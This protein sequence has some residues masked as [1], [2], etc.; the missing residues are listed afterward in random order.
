MKRI[1]T[2]I[3]LGFLSFFGISQTVS[4]Y[5]LDL[6]NVGATVND[7][8][9]FFNNAS[10]SFPGYSIPDGSGLHTLYAMGFWYGGVDVGGQLKFSGQ[11]YDPLSDQ[12]KG[13][14]TTDGSAQ[15]DNSGQWT[16][17]LFP[18]NHYD[19]TTHIAN[20]MNPGYVVPAQIA[21]WPAH[22]DVSNNFDYYLAPFV[23][24]DL[25]GI[26]DPSNG[27][28]P[29]IR[30]DKAVYV[31]MNDKGGLHAS[32]GD[33]IGIEMHYMFYQYAT[34]DDINNTTFVH[35][36]VINRGT[37]T[38]FDFKL[39]AFLDGDIGFYGDDYFG[40]DST[41]NMMYFYNGDNFDDYP[42]N[43]DG[44]QNAPPAAGIISLTHDFESIG[45][46]DDLAASAPAYWNAMNA[47]SYNGVPWS[48]PGTTTP[49]NFMYP[50]DPSVPSEMYSEVA[51]ANPPGDRRGV[52]TIDFGTLSAFAELDF[53]YAI[54]Y[55]RDLVDNVDN[56]VGL[57]TV[58]DNVQAFFDATLAD[59]CLANLVGLSELT[60]IDFS[61]FPNPSNGDFT[62]SIGVDFLLAE[63]QI[64][65]LSGRSV[66]QK[67]ELTSN[68]ITIN[69]NESSGVYLLNL[70]V[71][72]RKFTKRISVE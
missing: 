9:V 43:G 28:Y 41:R 62:L 23:D 49:V 31:I 54:I 29:C 42:A 50:D 10:V 13:P 30:G 35:G 63:V 21:N 52:A 3:L 47:T 45:F 68:E 70:S 67:S 69:L 33:P 56:A 22:G 40:S 15:P 46:V 18:I 6:N 20:Y 7:G 64:F 38:L 2:L 25:D 11:K 14:L 17:A 16:S 71:D 60:A 37:Q 8:G 39:S 19:I 12:F 32:G 65:D 72:G 66:F 57:K 44:Y 4:N 1:S 5:Y 55:N 61:I 51:Q 53:D 24:I 34:A 48:H 26:Y 58:A 59:D 27:D 36:K